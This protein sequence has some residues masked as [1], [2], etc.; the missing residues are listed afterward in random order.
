LAEAEAEAGAD[1]DRHFTMTPDPEGP[2][3]RV[4]GRLT[5]EGAA[6]IRAAMDPLCQPVPSDTRSAG[7]R[8]ADAV[9][10]VCRLALATTNLP[11]NGG[12]RPQVVLGVQYDVLKRELGAGT[13]DNGEQVTPET[14]R[15]LACDAQLLP[16]VFDGP[17]QPLDVGRTKR[18]FTGALRKA[19]VVR[20]Q[21]CTFPGCDRRARW[22]DGHHVVPH[23]AGGPTSLGNAA[24][25]CGFH[26]TELHKTGG[27]TMFIAPDGLPTFIPPRHVD[28]EQRPRRNRYHRRN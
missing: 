12:D 3:V 19:I 2:G 11:D 22:C 16:V 17:S 18:L 25:L 4:R 14:A 23:W 1:R 10:D 21:G 24:L 9:V 7:Q 27:W 5:A 8:R 15:R 28:P 13:L 6:V 26:H 20:D